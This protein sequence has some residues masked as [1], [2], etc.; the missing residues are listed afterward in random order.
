MPTATPGTFW[1]CISASTKLSTAARSSLR[2]HSAVAADHHPPLLVEDAHV[3]LLHRVA[4]D[5]G[6]AVANDLHV[7]RDGRGLLLVSDLLQGLRHVIRMGLA[8]ADRDSI[9]P[10]VFR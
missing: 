5:V 8:L 2:P 9:R 6:A 1:R 3:V 4:D 7:H 10:S